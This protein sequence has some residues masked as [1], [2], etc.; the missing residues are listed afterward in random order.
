MSTSALQA[1]EEPVDSPH[2]KCY[3]FRKCNVELRHEEKNSIFGI[4][5]LNSNM[6]GILNF[7]INM[8]LKHCCDCCCGFLLSEPKT[9]SLLFTK[10]K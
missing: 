10:Y 8:K 2:E 7:R 5:S 3:F 1:G 9:L 4:K 6:F